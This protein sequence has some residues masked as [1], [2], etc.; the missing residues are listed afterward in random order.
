MKCVGVAL[1]V[2][3][4]AV[5]PVF[6]QAPATSR[7]VFIDAVE[8]AGDSRT[9]NNWRTY[10]GS[11]SKTK[12]A[13]RELA[14]TIRNMSALPGQFSIEWYFVGKPANGTRRFLYDKGEKQV[15]LT[16]SSFEKF[17][18]ESKDLTS[19][20]V[21]DSYYYYGYNYKSGD[22]PDGWIIRAKVGDDVVRVKASSPQLE[23]L[24]K[25]KEEF[26]KF[27]EKQK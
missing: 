6:A 22:R 3:L 8:S 23:Q 11:Y 26:A 25:N 24:E 16:P 4:D 12:V 18:V 2:V 9:T 21:R 7:S 14:I 17:S 5:W 27:V 1:I 20:A 10:D 19:K 13:S 15:T